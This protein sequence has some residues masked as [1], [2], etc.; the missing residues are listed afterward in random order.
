MGF[1]RRLL[2]NHPLAN[3]T[4]A[5][6]LMLGILSYVHM[7]RAQDPEINF[8][9][10][11]IITVLPGASAADVEREI[12]SPLEDAIRQ[13]KDIRY[14]ASNSRE[15]ISSTC[16]GASSTNAWSTCGAKCRTRQAPSCPPRRATRW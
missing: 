8:N 16:Q 3:I 7:P 14:I 9:W 10:V 5:V 1:Y 12:T 4:F 6:V 15:G 11:S 2:R 13:V